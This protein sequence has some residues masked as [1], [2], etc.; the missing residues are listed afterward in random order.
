MLEDYVNPKHVLNIFITGNYTLHRPSPYFS[1]SDLISFLHFFKGLTI[2]KQNMVLYGLE[3]NFDD[4]E[5]YDDLPDEI[6]F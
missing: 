2:E 1:T 5:T 6:P 3:I 4:I